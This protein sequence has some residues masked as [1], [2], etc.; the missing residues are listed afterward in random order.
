MVFFDTKKIETHI[1]NRTITT[2][3]FIIYTIFVIGIFTNLV[4]IDIFYF[5]IG[6]IV[7]IDP[8]G[9]KIFVLTILLLIK[10]IFCY[11]IIKEKDINIF[12]YAVIPLTF[13]LRFKYFLL[14]YLPLT[15]LSLCMIRFV[16]L[17][18]E[19]W[20]FLGLLS[21]PIIEIIMHIFITIH[22]IKVI[23][24]IYKN[25]MDKNNEKVNNKEANIEI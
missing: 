14:I 5:N 12:L 8:S 1:K 2:R 25:A 6:D 23:R 20:V 11:K 7:S 13:V 19:V 10:Y 17:S 24:R 3:Q 22:F 4:I 18:Y 9:A 21:I 16:N 15:I